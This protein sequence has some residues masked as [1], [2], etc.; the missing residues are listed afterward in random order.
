MVE[1]VRSS[2]EEW[3]A[4]NGWHSKSEEEQ[5]EI[6]LKELHQHR[7]VSPASQLFDN[8]TAL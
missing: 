8:F 6:Q 7:H 3:K 2:V 4:Q 1:G 5:Q